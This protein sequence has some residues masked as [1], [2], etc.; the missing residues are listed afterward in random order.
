[1]SHKDKGDRPLF[2]TLSE[3]HVHTETNRWLLE[4]LDTVASTGISLQTHAS[5]APSIPKVLAL[6]DTALNRLMD[7]TTT[8]F[9]WFDDDGLECD[10]IYAHTQDAETVLRTELE[11]QI[12]RDVFGW[13]LSQDRPV[14]TTTTTSGKR[15]ILGPMATHERYL[16]MFI[17]ITDQAFIPDAALKL[18]SILL[19]NGV[20][21]LENQRLYA[22][23]NAHSQNLQEMVDERT[24]AL[25]QS[26][27]QL[28]RAIEKA[29]QLAQEAAT[30]NQ[31]KS[32]FLAN[33]SHEIRTPMNGVMG[34][35]ELLLHTDLAEEQRNYANTILHSGSQLVSLLNDILDFSKIEADKLELEETP[36]DLEEVSTEV[37]Q[38]LTLNAQSKGL[39]ILF[40]YAPNTP[41]GVIGDPG[42]IRQILINLLGNAIK[43]TEKGHVFINIETAA[44][45][46]EDKEDGD[47][48]VTFSI[49]VSDT[50]IGIAQDKLTHIFD[51]FAQADQ[52]TTRRYG[53]TGL[54]LAI[55]RRL[56]EKMGGAIH[57][58]SAP[59]QGS[60]FSFTLQLSVDT[61]APPCLR[62]RPKGAPEKL[63]LVAQQGKRAELLDEMLTDWG[64]KACVRHSGREALAELMK[65]L[66][67]E[68][69]YPLAFI[70]EQVAG[71]SVE[72]ICMA[73]RMSPELQSLKLIAMTRFSNTINSTNVSE[74]GITKL[75][76]KP[77]FPQVL[78]DTLCEIYG[79]ATEAEKGK[80]GA[81]LHTLLN[82]AS[83]E[84]ARPCIL[85]AEDNVVN[86][87]VIQEMLKQLGCEVE[88]AAN[89][90]QALQRTQEAVYDLI[91]MD[92]HMPEMDG[93][94]ATLALREWEAKHFSP[95]DTARIVVA[96]TANAMK[97]D[98]EMCLAAGMNDY[99]SK[100]IRRN[101][102][103]TIL[104]KYIPS[105]S[106]K[107]CEHGNTRILVAENDDT[108]RETLCALLQRNLPTAQLRR[109]KTVVEAYTFIGSF[110]PTLILLDE[111]IPG[112]RAAELLHFCTTFSR[113]KDT[114]ILVWRPCAHP[115]APPP[116]PH[117]LIQYLRTLLQECKPKS[118]LELYSECPH[119]SPAAAG[120]SPAPQPLLCMK[121]ALETT[122]GNLELLHS[123]AELTMQEAPKVFENLKE[124]VTDGDAAQA[125]LFA[126][127]LKGQAANFGAVELQQ[128]AYHAEQ[129]ASK[130]QWT[131]LSSLL[132]CLSEQL[133]TFC[134]ELEALRKKRLPPAEKM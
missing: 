93:L 1:M 63:L 52:S 97:G 37:I 20:D 28:E 121:T 129:A 2:E 90:R 38:L 70:D 4:C 118:Q 6:L 85:V 7:F 49:E 109:A 15:T 92:V 18:L 10:L 81:L 25:A 45:A 40:R 12:E 133:D 39:D 134:S 30:A 11:A 16:G 23:L 122:A 80:E 19:L 35:A 102:V 95:E 82:D 79:E 119:E 9:A 73:V 125:R 58:S 124:A 71:E 112:I 14:V 131:Q 50:G 8:G 88:I 84:E 127:T 64:F 107:A 128:T 98:R 116:P 104:K 72:N 21:T 13:A 31:T 26:N 61:D 46:G 74:I 29:N 110:V 132:P 117:D 103:A 42:R 99:L 54:G 36:F 51:V 77:V 5:E 111:E 55:C 96:M 33:M 86:Q 130:S 91:F 65:A 89:G 113:Y 27:F 101:D 76:R 62:R 60:T 59:Q 69:P 67:D 22:A 115:A 75:L 94:S 44:P 120:A 56:V 41:R 126:H 106:L 47:G 66:L 108:Q 48:R 78:Y 105:F 53:G 114:Q 43:F 34:M 3:D 123:V 57:A 87:R 24:H 32:Q 17:G 68:T 100:P 83:A